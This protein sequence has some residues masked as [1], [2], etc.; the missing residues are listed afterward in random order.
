MIGVCR[1]V[2]TVIVT[3]ALLC[4]RRQGLASDMYP[5]AIPP[6]YIRHFHAI[7]MLAPGI[8]R[9]CMQLALLDGHVRYGSI[10]IQR[11]IG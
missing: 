7:L 3:V 2:G 5:S 11:M 6:N 8:A 10:T 9:Y 1:P 4:Y